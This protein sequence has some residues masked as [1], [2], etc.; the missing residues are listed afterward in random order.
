MIYLD[1][2][3]TSYHK[4]KSVSDAVMAAM[5]EQGSYGRG[6]YEISLEAG[7]AIYGTRVKLAKLLGINDPDQIAF[8]HNATESL[9]IAIH[10]I[11]DEGT[12]IITTESEH[13]SVLRPLY[14]QE[15]RGTELSFLEVDQKGVLQYQ[16]LQSLLK[17]NT[18]AVVCTHASNV[19]G[20][21]TD[22]KGC[23][24][25]VMNII[26]YLLLMDHKV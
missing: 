17:S 24:I 15:N 12:H 25:F 2:A 20:N 5:Q 23:V 11:C 21:I 3:A 22:L 13:N 8:T 6:G 7:R 14:Y 9:N 1:H 18:K 10:G 4:P 26:Y 16:Q 19:S